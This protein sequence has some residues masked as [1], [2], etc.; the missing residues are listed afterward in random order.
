MKASSIYSAANPDPVYRAREA[1]NDTNGGLL[2][3][4]LDQLPPGYGSNRPAVPPG[5]NTGQT[6]N[7]GQTG[8]TGQTTNPGQIANPPNTANVSDF[9]QQVF[10]LVNQERQNAG[11]GALT[12]DSK[13]VQVARAKAQDMH[14]K[15][16]FDH[17]SPTYGSPF[18][19]MKTF[20]VSFQSAGENIAKGQTSPEQVMSQ[21]MNSPGHRANILNG[22][23]THIGVGYA[24]TG[25]WVQEFVGR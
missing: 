8:N 4:L 22:G 20:G 16:Y 9:E 1:T 7:A 25:E 17:Q 23:F 2:N 13:L 19:M 18:D 15:N 24:S 3:R 12:M 5:Q 11:L 14:D 6:G 21:W 10:E